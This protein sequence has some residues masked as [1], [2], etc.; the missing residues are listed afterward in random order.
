MPTAVAARGRPRDPTVDKRVLRATVA[1]LR[2]RGVAGTTVNA[3]ARRA[4]VARASIY[5]RYPSRDRLITAAIRA[6]IGRE[7][8]LASGDLE[9]DIR[10]TAEQAR[11]IFSSR[12]LQRLL[13]PLIEGLLQP[14]NSPTALSYDIL[15]P[16]RRVL[17]N[18]YRELASATGFRT[19]VDPETVFDQ[20]V[21]PI[22]NR[23]LVTGTAPAADE[24]DAL[25]DVLIKGLRARG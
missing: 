8:I 6:A 2:E 23:L 13:P 20:I 14:R 25:V 10:R 11:A 21:G 17:V 7:P 12:Q 15:A 16:N 18:E 22:L 19:D 3:V 24:V 5:L 9:R 4:G 1:I